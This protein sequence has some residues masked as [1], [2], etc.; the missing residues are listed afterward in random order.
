MSPGL[1]FPIVQNYAYTQEL[2]LSFISNKICH[3]SCEMKLITSLDMA[4]YSIYSYN[5]VMIKY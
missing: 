2:T 3:L 5:Y 4:S 1:Q